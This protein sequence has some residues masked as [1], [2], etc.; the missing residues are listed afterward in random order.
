[1]AKTKKKTPKPSSKELDREHV[2]K[3][4]NELRTLV[5]RHISSN[6][7]G[8]Y[9]RDN[10][11]GYLNNVRS[12]LLAADDKRLVSSLKAKICA[13]LRV[14]SDDKRP[15]FRR[16]HFF[17]WVADNVPGAKELLPLL[18]DTSTCPDTFMRSIR[19]TF[20]RKPR[21]PRPDAGND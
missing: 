3:L 8:S 15:Q 13:T 7:R 5:Y 21:A 18:D 17:L 16:V 2:T 9:T 11:E 14:T 6:T 19:E 1:M 4:I 20:Q 10:V 12:G